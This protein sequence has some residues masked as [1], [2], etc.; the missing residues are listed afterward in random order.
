MKTYREHTVCR[1]ADASF[2]RFVRNFDIIMDNFDN[3]LSNDILDI[4]NK[5]THILAII[6]YELDF[7]EDEIEH[8]TI[9][10]Q[11]HHLKIFNIIFT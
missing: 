5:I 3:K 1:Y 9:K 10:K 4:N 6:E 8:I 7:S 2:L 11:K